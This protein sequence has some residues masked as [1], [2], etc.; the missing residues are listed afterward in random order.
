MTFNRDNRGLRTNGHLLSRSFVLRIEVTYRFFVKK[1]CIP[2][3]AISKD[4]IHYFRSPLKNQQSFAVCSR[5]RKKK[6]RNW[7]RYGAQLLSTI[8][9]R[10]KV[11]VAFK[12]DDLLYT[13][14]RVQDLYRVCRRSPSPLEL[15]K[16]ISSR[17][18]KKN[19]HLYCALIKEIIYVQSVFQGSVYR[20][21]L[22]EILLSLT[23]NIIIPL[24]GVTILSILAV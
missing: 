11:H 17:F 16:Y 5:H 12:H 15:A 19:W 10:L 23:F 7:A 2:A 20:K 18:M 4:V 6:F 14:R 13:C 3:V 1:G 8:K 22:F 24:F 9:K 21:D